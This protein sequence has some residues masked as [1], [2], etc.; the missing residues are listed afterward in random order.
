[1]NEFYLNMTMELNKYFKS[2]SVELSRS[3]I[4]L[5][6]YNPRTISEEA[7]KSLKR[8]IKKYGLLGGI[9]VNKR[10]GMT[11]VSGHQRLAVMDELNKFPDSDY[12]IR[13]D[14]IDVDAKAEKELNILLNNPN[15]MGSWDYDALRELIPDIDYKDAGLTEED[16]NL[17]GC[18]F[19]LQ[20]DAEN[21]LA[22]ALNDVMSEVN[23]QNEAD[24]A[25]R[26]LERA[27][28]TAHMKEV[29]E[30]V[31][32]SANDKAQDMD[33]YVMLSFDNY[34]ARV[35][36]MERFGYGSDEK[37]IKGEVFSEQVERVD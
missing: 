7:K 13:V 11:V 3:A 17:I 36:F 10:T 26:Q 29:K 8:G 20:T 5:A 1:M 33:A 14:V 9:I 2:Q 35:A 19:L 4:H 18:D 12:A 37:F 25:Q 23:E 15:A 28:K 22:D 21:S 34:A 27:E 32:Q 6:N 30:Q 16:L 24:K 31:K